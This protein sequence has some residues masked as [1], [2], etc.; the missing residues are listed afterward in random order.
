[1]AA[2]SDE[3]CAECRSSNL[4]VVSIRD[5]H[6]PPR[7]R[8]PPG[9]ERTVAARKVEVRCRRCGWSDCIVRRTD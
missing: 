9:T 8:E 6:R 5:V 4:E 7:E 1:M 3:R 2:E